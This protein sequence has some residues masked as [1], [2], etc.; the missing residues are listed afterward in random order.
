MYVHCKIPFMR[1][2][3]YVILISMFACLQGQGQ[4]LVNNPGFENVNANCAS[5]TGAGY[6]NLAD[7]YNPDPT[8][9]CS[10]PDWFATCLNAIF[11]T[12]APNSQLGY[13]VPHGGNA[14]AGF[15]AYDQSTASYREY[16]E[17]S[18]SAPLVAAQKYKVSFFLSLANGAHFSVNH[19]GV[20]FS[21]ALNSFTTS[22]CVSVNP[23][24]NT[25]QID[26]TFTI[27]DTTNWVALEWTYTA[28]GGEQYFTIGNFHDNA[29]TT[30]T[31]VPH[32][33]TSFTPYAYYFIDDV[34]VLADTTTADTT[35]TSNPEGIRNAYYNSQALS[36]YPNPA[37]SYINI[38]C[39]GMNEISFINNTGMVVYRR[40]T[41]TGHENIDLGK[42]PKGIYM[43][44]VRTTKGVIVRRLEVF[45]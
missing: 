29:N 16:V 22:H 28:S 18:L 36:M 31:A 42:L 7:W 1:R 2:S 40:E 12:H 9:T 13:Q 38:D 35:D 37:R 30:A 32:S 43:V 15:I 20:Y 6:V 41:N 5:L 14:Y 4:N 19:L 27:T 44:R 39:Q 10:T 11:P 25:P 23:L 8:D 24:T 26:S 3:L 34:S 33:I 21:N 17:G 45:K